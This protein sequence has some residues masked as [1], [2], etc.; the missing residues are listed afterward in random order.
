MSNK[1]NEIGSGL[2][3]TNK[4]FGYSS[5]INCFSIAQVASRS[6]TP[7]ERKH[8]EEGIRK[9]TYLT[10]GRWASLMNYFYL[11]KIEIYQK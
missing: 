4:H 1:I 6:L 11:N 8:V 7:Y 2:Q 5:A 3:I 9:R 10:Q